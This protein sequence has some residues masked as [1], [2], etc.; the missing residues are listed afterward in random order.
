M[1][2]EPGHFDIRS[3]GDKDGPS[4]R[5]VWRLI[6]DTGKTM[7]NSVDSFDSREAVEDHVAWIRA[8]AASCAV[9]ITPP[10]PYRS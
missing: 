2:D 8:N 10:P 9:K 5:W 3:W 4:T 7:A 1:A 6:S